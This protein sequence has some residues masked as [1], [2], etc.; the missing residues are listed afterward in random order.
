MHFQSTAIEGVVLINPTV[1]SDSRGFFFES[2]QERRFS[3]AGVDARFVQDNHSR[4]IKNTLR[5]MHYQVGCGQGKLVRAVTGT[6]FDVAVDIRRSS[7]TFG[8]W[9]G[10]ELSED[11]QRILWVPPGFAHGFLV[12]S[13]RADVVYRCTEFWQPENERAIAWDDSDL[14]ILWPLVDGE[15]PVLS[16]KD[17]A[18]KRFAEAECFP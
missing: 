7:T 15:A 6:I 8:K 12:L 1:L 2:W 4:S 5:G 9:V 11:N 17:A 18:A 16:R 13:E 14:K 10:M 3:A